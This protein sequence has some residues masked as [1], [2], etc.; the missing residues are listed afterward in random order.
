MELIRVPR[1]GLPQGFQVKRP[2]HKRTAEKSQ[3]S[4]GKKQVYACV[5]SIRTRSGKR[6]EVTTVPTEANRAAIEACRHAMLYSPE[7]ESRMEALS[8][9]CGSQTTDYVQAQKSG[10]D[11]EFCA[12][13]ADERGETIELEVE[14][15][16][17][18]YDPELDPDNC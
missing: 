8:G 14:T 3:K 16:E 9:G 2:R 12:R 13:L 15:D 11:E 18:P 17:E 1:G 4:C 10:Y 7:V 5:D 6:V